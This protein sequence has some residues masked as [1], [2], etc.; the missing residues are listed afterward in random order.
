MYRRAGVSPFINGMW[1]TVLRDMVFGGTYTWLRTYLKEELPGE[2]AWA[3]NMTAAAMAT[4]VS[5]SVVAFPNLVG[6]SLELLLQ[7]WSVPSPLVQA[8]RDITAGLGC[9]S[10]S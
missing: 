10:N 3:A 9:E 5:G 7:R 1:P 8:S 2:T 4:V 6:F